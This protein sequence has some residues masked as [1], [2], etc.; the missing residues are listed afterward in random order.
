MHVLALIV[1]H[2]PAGGHYIRR[3]LPAARFVRMLLGLFND[4]QELATFKSA[5]EAV[6]SHVDMPANLLLG[7]LALL[8]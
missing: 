2:G 7:G 3:A 1:C 5:I 6:K 8:R 4:W